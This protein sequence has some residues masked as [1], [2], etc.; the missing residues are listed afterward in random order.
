MKYLLDTDHLS[1]LQR[2]AGPEYFRLSAWMGQFTAA[3]FACCVVSLHEQV[4]GAHA[5]LNQAKNS[6]VLM[7]GYA[8]LERLPRDYLAFT[9]LPFDAASASIYDHLLGQNLRIG[10]MD[11]RL[12]GIALE[13]NLTVLTRNIRDFS[14]VPGLTI[15]DRTV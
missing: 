6:A 10:A 8:L 7:R 9:L 3:D 14:R 11:L 12:S 4:V 15:E 13:R 1:I 5:F 2:K